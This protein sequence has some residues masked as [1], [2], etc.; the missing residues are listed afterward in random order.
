M[1]E[2][3][4]DYAT[5]KNLL[6]ASGGDYQVMAEKLVDILEVAYPKPQPPGERIPT[7]AEEEEEITDLGTR[8]AANLK[9]GRGGDKTKRVEYSNHL[10]NK[11]LAFQDRQTT[12]NIPSPDPQREAKIVSLTSELAELIKMPSRSLTPVLKERKKAIHAE[13]ANLVPRGG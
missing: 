6:D 11:L 13:L 1:A 10:K 3:N 2:N 4:F 8:L 9:Q 5:L 12:A 7:L